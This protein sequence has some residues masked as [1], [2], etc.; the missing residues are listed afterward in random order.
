[1][2]GSM[3]TLKEEFIQLG[4]FTTEPLLFNERL[5]EWLIEYDFNRPHQSLGYLSAIEY[6]NNY[7]KVLPMSP[8]STST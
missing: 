4:N 1:M 3:R 8:S 2:K 7:Q 5:T 6:L